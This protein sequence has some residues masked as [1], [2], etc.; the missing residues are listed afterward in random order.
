[1]QDQS[2]ITCPNCGTE[3]DVQNVLTHQIEEDLKK[4]HELQ[5]AEDKRKFD[6]QANELK[7]EKLEFAAKKAREN[8]LF[9]ERVDS[10]VKETEKLLEPKLKARIEAEKAE[11]VDLMQ[12]ELDQKSKQVIELNKSKAEIAKLKRDNNEM[13]DLDIPVLTVPPVSVYQCHPF[14]F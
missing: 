13:R 5:H 1:M 8:E 14:R 3:I 11:E 12:K 2:K 6:E 10:K 9:Q 4:S 7:N